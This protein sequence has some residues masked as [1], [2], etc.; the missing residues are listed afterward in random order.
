MAGGWQ[1]ADTILGPL[2]CGPVLVPLVPPGNPYWGD[3]IEAWRMRLLSWL[4]RS[5]IG[6]E[7]EEGCA[8]LVAE[9]G[10]LFGVVALVR[11]DFLADPAAAGE[12]V[13]RAIEVASS[14]TMGWGKFRPG[15]GYPAAVRR[16]GQGALIID[17]SVERIDVDALGRCVAARCARLIGGVGERGVV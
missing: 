14:P 10:P 17:P 2:G 3:Q 8:P 6:V 11:R 13:A 9:H 5:P 1:F 16:L 4:P 12:W 15:D 7:L